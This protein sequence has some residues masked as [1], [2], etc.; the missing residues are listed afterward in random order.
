MEADR[1][2]GHMIEV[3]RMVRQSVLVQ[4]GKQ[5]RHWLVG[6]SRRGRRYIQDEV[7]VDTLALLTSDWTDA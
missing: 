6:R 5:K 1:F 2:S 3:R 7:E 4:A